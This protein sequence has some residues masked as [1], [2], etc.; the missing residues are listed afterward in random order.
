MTGDQ[1]NLL[2]RTYLGDAPAAQSDAFYQ[3][4]QRFYGGYRFADNPDEKLKELFH[5]GLV[6]HFL[7][8]HKKSVYLTG[9]RQSPAMHPSYLLESID[10]L[11]IYL[12]NDVMDIMATGFLRASVQAEFG[13]ADL[14]RMSG[15]DRPTALS[16]LVHLGVLTRGAEPDVLRIPNEKMEQLV[17]QAFFALVGSPAELVHLRFCITS[18]ST[19][20]PKRNFRRWRCLQPEIF[21]EGTRKS[22]WA[23]WNN[24]WPKGFC[25]RPL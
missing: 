17:C 2:I 22:L 11:C 8:Q 25:N 9:P 3:A 21:K 12:I 23:D 13:F 10:K 14:M 16:L 7:L 6:Y 5:P 4:I 18:G 1:V 15:N 20:F 19:R 24:S